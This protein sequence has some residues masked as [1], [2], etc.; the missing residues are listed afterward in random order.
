MWKVFRESVWSFLWGKVVSVLGILGTAQTIISLF[1]PNYVI[2]IANVVKIDYRVWFVF[3]IVLAIVVILRVLHTANQYKHLLEAEDSIRIVYSEKYYPACRQKQNNNEE[4]I[5]VGVRVI[6]RNAVENLEVF[7]SLLS[8][9]SKGKKYKRRMI[10]RFALSSMF[11]DMLLRPVNPGATPT[12]F[13]NLLRHKLG[14]SEVAFCYRD[15]PT[16]YMSL[17]AG[18]Y[19]LDVRARCQSNQYGFRTLFISFDT[20]GNLTVKPAKESVI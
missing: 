15:S 12:C 1:E 20:Q 16:E 14:T 8:R 10:N 17:N 2:T 9:I 11:P 18:K 4:V 5:R 7:P 6:G 3:T 19:E 13:V